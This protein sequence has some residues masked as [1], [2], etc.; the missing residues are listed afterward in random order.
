ME[1]KRHEKKGG[2]L[3]FYKKLNV[4]TLAG[5]TALFLATGAPI[6]EA[7]ALFDVAQIGVIEGVER[8]RNN[9][10]KSAA[11]PLGGVALAK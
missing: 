10:K 2:P 11:K 6:F 7:A 3:N 9:R 8:I 1:G 5:S 4:I